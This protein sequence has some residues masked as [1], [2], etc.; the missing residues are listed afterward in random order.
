MVCT[1]SEVGAFHLCS[2]HEGGP[3]YCEALSFGSFVVLLGFFNVRLKYSTGRSSWSSC[4]CRM[5]NP[6][7]SAFASISRTYLSSARGRE[8]TVCYVR[9][10]FSSSKAASCV[11]VSVKSSLATFLSCL[12]SGAATGPNSF[13]NLRYTLHRPKKD[14]SCVL[15]TGLLIFFEHHRWFSGLQRALSVWRCGLDTLWS[16]IWRRAFLT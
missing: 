10:F 11:S 9:R 5:T 8:K 15:F 14:R 2:E 12:L 6:S 3:Y 7:W 1:Y 16:R 4:S 13:T